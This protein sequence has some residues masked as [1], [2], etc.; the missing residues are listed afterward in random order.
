MKN[1]KNLLRKL[2][3]II[4][5]IFSIFGAQTTFAL[6]RAIFPD[7]KSLQPMPPDVHANISGNINSVTE[8]LP[9]N[10]ASEQNTPENQDNFSNETSSSVNNQK[11]F[12]F[13]A[14]LGAIILLIIIGFKK[15]KK[16]VDAEL[17]K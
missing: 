4:I 12:I 15:L 6:K 17:G 8:V 3:I 5:L 14:V 16:K 2:F 1:K 13:Y 9:D 7:G 11:N 10:N